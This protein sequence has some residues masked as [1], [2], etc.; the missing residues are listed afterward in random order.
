MIRELDVIK[1]VCSMTGYGRST[2]RNDQHTI[3]AEMK[4]VNHRFFEINVRMPR[5]LMSVED[6]I[7]KVISSEVKRGRVEVYITIEGE[8]LA[9]RVIEVDWKLLDQYADA[10]SEMENRYQ[11]GSR[12][13]LSDLFSLDSVFSVVE[14]AKG[15]E[16]LEE[17][18]LSAV[19]GAAMQLKDMRREEGSYLKNDLLKQLS[20]I[21]AFADEIEK[22]APDV[23]LRYKNRLEKKMA[24]LSGGSIDDS[25]IAAEAA[26]FADRADISEEITRIR[27]HLLQFRQTIEKPEPA[28][29][30]LDFLVQELNRE[31]NTIGSK[32]ND[33]EISRCSVEL[34]SVIERIKEQVQN[35]E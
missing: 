14:M 4:S 19:R 31:A 11:T 34:K 1:M 25:R 32:A 29:R 6:K 18:I 9:E 3:T 2:E 21:E 27:S 10:A 8:A 35:I 13:K 26:L 20:E 33:K 22:H 16:T 23:V 28:G 17:L 30:K 24:E 15:N 5:Q 12:L 7:K